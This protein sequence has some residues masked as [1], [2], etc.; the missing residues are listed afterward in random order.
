MLGSVEEVTLAGMGQSRGI[1][2]IDMPT[3]EKAYK[4]LLDN[5]AIE[6]PIELSKGFDDRFWN[7]VSDAD[8]K[9]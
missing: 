5:K 2:Y 6:S 7:A 4:M 3:V 8:K 1:G 9:M